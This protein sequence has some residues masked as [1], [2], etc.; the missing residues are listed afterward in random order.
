MK[1]HV[2]TKEAFNVIGLELKTTSQRAEVEVG[3]LWHKFIAENTPDQIPNTTHIEPVALYY[4][5]GGQGM[6]CSMGP[7]S[8][9]ILLGCKVANLDQIPVGMTGK[10]VPEQKYAV[11]TITGKVP[12]SIIQAWQEINAL[13]LNRSML[14]DFEDYKYIQE[15]MVVHDV[16]LGTSLTETFEEPITEVDIYVGIKEK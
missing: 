10:A 7:D 6:C 4:D 16:R 8:Y 12:E 11:F 9:A 15:P 2:K 1:Y 5:Y 14:Y 13:G 3:Q